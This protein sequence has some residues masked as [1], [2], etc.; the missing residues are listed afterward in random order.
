MNAPVPSASLI[1]DYLTPDLAA[2]LARDGN[3]DPAAR[4]ALAATLR[5]TL[6]ACSAYVPERLVRAQMADPLPGRVSG[7][8][9]HGSL[10]FA[11][12]SGFTAFSEHLS[13]LGKQGAEEV[14]AVVNQLFGA[15]IAE[16][17]S[18][19]GTLLKFGGDALTA[20]F[21]SSL[22]GAAHA[23]AAAHA[24]L[25]MQQRMNDF[26]AVPTRMGTFRLALRVGVHSGELFAA[27]VGDRSH[28]EL[29]V[30]GPEVN[31]V[32]RAQ[33]IAAP[34]EVVVSDQ[35]AALLEGANL[36]PRRAG[37]QRIID[38]AATRLPIPGTG[39]L[40][41]E[42][43]DDLPIL[44]ALAQQVAALR[45]YLVRGLPRR[46]LDL[47]STELGEFRPV[48]V[49]F[50]NFYDF[51]T[52][53]SLPG[54]TASLA[55]TMLNAYIRRAQEAVHR[56]GGIINKVD[57][58]THGDKLMAL[59]GAPTAH[60]D[61]PLRAAHCAFELEAALHEARSEIADLLAPHIR[62]G[63]VRLSQRIGINTGT[64]FAGRVG[65]T[66]RY[67]YTVMGPAVNLAARL[68]GAAERGT[69][70]LSPAT[71]QAV[72]RQIDIVE[73]EPLHLKGLSAPIVPAVAVRP[74]EGERLVP[75]DATTGLVQPP[76]VGR[77][78]E[79]A[80]LTSAASEALRGQGRVIAVV[81]DAGIGK[82]RL[83][84]ELVQA[85]VLS[86]VSSQAA[87]A[88]P[89]F[90]ISTGDCQSYEQSTPYVALRV[91]LRH[92]LGVTPAPEQKIDPQ[93]MLTA[94]RSK[95]SQFAPQFERF[96]PLLGDVL[97]VSLAETS[98]TRMLSAEQR[99]NRLQE[100]VVALLVGESSRSPLLLVLDDVQWADASSLE[101]LGRLS[102]AIA[103]APL[104]VLLNYRPTPP[105]DEP[106]DEVPGTVSLKLGELAPDKSIDL[107]AA[108]LNEAPPP[109]MLALLER[110]QGNPFYIEE[111]V[112]TLVLS[113]DLT[114]DS[115]GQWHLSRPLD[116]AAI[117]SS[118]S[119][120]IVARLDRLD[121]ARYELV[122]VASVIG[123]R[124]QHP[125]LAGVYSLPHLLDACLHDLHR[126]EIVQPDPY[127][128]M[129]S[130]LFRHA[131]LRDVAYEAI[132]YARRRELHL[133]VAQRIEELSA[134]WPDETLSLLAR[135]YLLAEVWEPA[136]RY[137]IA[138]GVQ[139]Q[140]RYANREALTLFATALDI[141]TH[142]EQDAAG[143]E[144]SGRVV[145]LHERQGNIHALLGEYDQARAAY[146]NALMRL[147]I[148]R[149]ELGLL[150][151]TADA[152]VALPAELA[153]LSVRLH[154]Q[155]ATVQ[156]WGSDYDSADD[157]LS[158]GIARSTDDTRDEL[159]RCSLLGA[160][161]CY[162]RGEFGRSLEWSYRSLEL[163]EQ[164]GLAADQ[165][166]A[167]RSIGD[168]L[169]DQGELTRSIA[170]LERAR[171]LWDEV[172]DLN[173][174]NSILNDLGAVYDQAGYWS[175]ATACYERSLE[176]SENTGDAHAIADTSNNLA[177]ILVRQ[178]EL[179][180]ADRLY[181][182]SAERYRE[183]GSGWGIALTT[184][185]RGEV[186]LLQG[187][188]A[189]ALE[190][191]RQSMA[192]FEQMGARSFL[193]EIVRLAAEAALALGDYEQAR[194]DAT[195]SLEI[196]R[197]LGMSVDAAVAQRVLGQV[198]LA[199]QQLAEAGAALEQ[200]FAALEQADE[201]YEMGRVRY[202]QA[203][204]WHASGDM[205][206]VAPALRQAA[207]LFGALGARRDLAMA[208]MLATSYG[209][210]VAVEPPPAAATTTK[211]TP[212]D[213]DNLPQAG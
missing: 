38:L 123:R 207:E 78:D 203:R 182:S 138:A 202:W 84:S 3:L 193:P 31:R 190:L 1:Y 169:A 45:P 19:R 51:S 118:I 201:R 33:E 41:P 154:R 152:P 20:F 115:A 108:M 159:A 71:W 91:P 36:I 95:V 17:R 191:F 24:A 87:D 165:A 35:T 168:L 60:E 67:E 157:W 172:N 134:N 167:L 114:R 39:P 30:T 82:T 9:W 119:G 126:A 180:R 144:L 99:H 72:E 164:L 57:M 73:Q 147:S 122:Q 189:Q 40:V 192:A 88:V 4:R 139:A 29:V 212:H 206:Q 77:D 54:C 14:S 146:M 85:L 50:A 12:L 93:E 22:L 23:A 16:V 150:S 132:L 128:P 15:L 110:T 42:G 156:Y 103:E 61:D 120:L 187:Q 163:A 129:P 32:A 161:L 112:R 196:A 44:E 153:A 160:K 49:L 171:A 62:A 21:D 140:Q 158:R 177:V 98:L 136:L 200:S 37:F 173:G 102:R 58:Y 151:T 186:L 79:L 68:M 63:E 111:L 135:H 142:L 89:P 90:T 204:L 18:H 83:S 8:F 213:A 205:E 181:T 105:I 178:G 74:R 26:A 176:I 209:L 25:A 34:S 96:T 13:A 124:F 137:H 125:V 106:W 94:L 211:S 179:D 131:L 2:Q 10:L 65:G 5:Q 55:A 166:L 188:P 141:V 185:N 197:E 116:Q 199:Q 121:E 175:E 28:I 52:L 66:R 97:G 7:T 143:A 194:A 86:S 130:Y 195:R 155:I 100:L 75:H 80:Y 149:Q 133:R 117:P 43:P 11:D 113:G 27:E 107:L 64:V 69:V 184:Y 198:A 210:P 174:L 208:R 170:A 109:A 148:W 81:G 145:E 47:S 70:L 104:L 76:L 92:L 56:Y 53:L 101:L 6:A 183:V 48:T 162:R 127:D 46:F 59:F